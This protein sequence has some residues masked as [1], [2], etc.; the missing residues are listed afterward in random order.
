MVC[1][2]GRFNFYT[3]LKISYQILYCHSDSS[4]DILDL[5]VT[6]KWQNIFIRILNKSLLVSAE[7]YRHCY[8][9]IMGI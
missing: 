8:F 7:K 9:V 6:T 4:Q 1:I 2:H 3:H 5:I